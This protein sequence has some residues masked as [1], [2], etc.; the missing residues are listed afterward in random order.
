MNVGV[1]VCVHNLVRGFVVVLGVRTAAG[2]C[3]C[4][5]SQSGRR[6]TASF[7]RFSFSQFR[8]WSCAVQSF[9]KSLVCILACCLST[10]SNFSRASIIVLVNFYGSNFEFRQRD[11]LNRWIHFICRVIL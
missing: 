2:E 3:N 10:Y 1:R 7:F 9:R 11:F 8:I 4:K 6:V 5:S